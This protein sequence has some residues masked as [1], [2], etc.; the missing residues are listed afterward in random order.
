MQEYQTTI[1]FADGGWAQH[2]GI[3]PTREEGVTNYLN[4][5]HPGRL[6]DTVRWMWTRPFP[7]EFTACVGCT[8]SGG[9]EES[10]R[11]REAA[12]RWIA[13]VMAS[14]RVRHITLYDNYT[15]ISHTVC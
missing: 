4:E 9:I 5:H 11:T 6:V 3:A 1:T 7:Q 10:F 15:G 13:K 14:P 12:M 2:G 8:M